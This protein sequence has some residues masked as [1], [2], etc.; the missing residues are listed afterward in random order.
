[1]VMNQHNGSVGEGGYASDSSETALKRPIG[2]YVAPDVISDDDGST[3]RVPAGDGNAD[4]TETVTQPLL[5][6]MAYALQS[7]TAEHVRTVI[8]GHFTVADITEA[9]MTLWKQCGG[10]II[11]VDMP[12]R[13]DS[14]ARSIAEAHVQ[15][16]LMAMNKLDNADKLP[17]FMIDA[18]SL[19]KIPRWHPEEVNTISL[20]DRMLR[21]ENKVAALQEAV[22]RNTAESLVRRDAHERMTY[23]NAAR[24][25]DAYQSRGEEVVMASEKRSENGD[26][27]AEAGPSRDGEIRRHT[28]GARRK[29]PARRAATPSPKRITVNGRGRVSGG[30]R[31]A[32]SGQVS[33]TDDGYSNTNRYAALARAESTESMASESASRL[34]TEERQHEEHD[35]REFQRPAHVIRRERNK[36]R[37]R[38]NIITGRHQPGA[39]RFRG[40]P[41]AE[42]HLFV[43][44]IHAETEAID[45]HELVSGLGH[46][47]RN[48]DCV[49][50][51]D[52]KYKSFK[53]TVSLRDYDKVYNVNFPWPEGV[54]VRRYNIPQRPRSD[55]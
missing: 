14:N 54:R 13:R 15:D 30:E 42:R 4:R 24:I 36:E 16:M 51:P 27:R 20:A 32:A 48:V 12:R 53:L 43:Y 7:S 45:I 41:E 18:Y 46:E 40:A 21:T 6:Y 38:R 50:H 23:A 47:V 44:R 55:T 9:K 33:R 34:T 2:E 22:D 35:N 1:M 28:A 3:N 19:G 39:G 52:S 8:T 29:T 17:L 31:A 5:A 26:T 11:G 49:S 25:Q 10:E 37:A